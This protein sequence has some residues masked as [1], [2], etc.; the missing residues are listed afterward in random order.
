MHGVACFKPEKKAKWKH[1]NTR[2]L[3]IQEKKTCVSLSFSFFL[4]WQVP[5]HESA[6][7]S[8]L[9]AARVTT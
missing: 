5:S 1:V 6:S 2:S 4:N 3:F 8:E 7:G 9:E